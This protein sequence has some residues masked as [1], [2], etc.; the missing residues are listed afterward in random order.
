MI[1]HNPEA[2][3]VAG[4]ILHMRDGRIVNEQPGTPSMGA[5]RS[6]RRKPEHPRRFDRHGPA[7]YTQPCEQAGVAQW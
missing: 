4:R 7:R 6:E 3:A 2:A 5:I 1:T